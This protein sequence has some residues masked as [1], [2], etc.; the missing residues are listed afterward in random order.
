MDLPL[1]ELPGRQSRRRRFAVGLGMVAS[2]ALLGAGALAPESA[3]AHAGEVHTEEPQAAA[4]VKGSGE[5]A[6]KSKDDIG[7]KESLSGGAAGPGTDES[8]K[9]GAE[10]SRSSS[11]PAPAE[12]ETDPLLH[13]AVLGVAALAGLGLLLVRRR[14]L[15][16]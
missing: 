6:G 3:L 12:P 16:G 9:S 13:F 14:R 8:G 7:G 10:G 1:T 2:I 5:D 4:P 15:A 11:P